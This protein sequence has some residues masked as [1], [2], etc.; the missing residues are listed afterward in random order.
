MLIRSTCTANNS[1]QIMIYAM[2]MIFFQALWSE[3]GTQVVTYGVNAQ[4]TEACKIGWIKST[5]RITWKH[6]KP[7]N[8]SMSDHNRARTLARLRFCGMYRTGRSETPQDRSELK[9][10]LIHELNKYIWRFKYC[11]L[12]TRQLYGWR[13]PVKKDHAMW[14]MKCMLYNVAKKKEKKKKNNYV[15]MFKWQRHASYDN[16]WM[17]SLLIMGKNYLDEVRNWDMWGHSWA[18]V[19]RSC[20]GRQDIRATL[21]ELHISTWSSL[22]H[23]QWPCT[24]K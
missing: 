22:L 23:R 18:Q 9:E 4:K 17:Q 8:G 19:K 21:Y 13:S 12:D 24:M 14:K 3:A 2:I 16:N 11:N 20:C 15:L 5:W 7:V 10:W 1:L 6:T